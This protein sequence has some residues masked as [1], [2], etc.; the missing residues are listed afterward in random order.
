MRCLWIVAGRRK[1]WAV[2]G[3]CAFHPIPNINVIV[4]YLC[5]QY[6]YTSGCQ[7]R[8]PPFTNILTRFDERWWPLVPENCPSQKK[9]CSLSSWTII[10]QEN[11]HQSLGENWK[12]VFWLLSQLPARSREGDM[13]LSICLVVCRLLQEQVIT[14]WNSLIVWSCFR[15]RSD[16]HH[17]LQVVLR[18]CFCVGSVWVLHCLMLHKNRT[19]GRTEMVVSGLRGEAGLWLVAQRGADQE[20]TWSQ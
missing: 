13:F 15:F 8:S 14:D 4:L 3:F 12:L 20:A 11:P 5:A 7:S 18:P 9:G 6:V 1:I 19:V 10:Y 16:T 17:Y 2:I